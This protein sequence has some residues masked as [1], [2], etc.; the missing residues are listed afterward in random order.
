[1]SASGTT[2]PTLTVD[3]TSLATNASA[4]FASAFTVAYGADGAG[5]TT[6]ALAVANS[7]SG[8]IDVA[9]GE[10]IVLSTDASGNVVGKTATGG[11]TVFTISV[12]SSGVV[13]LDQVRAIKH[14]DA[15]NADDSVSL[16]ANSITLTATATDKDGDTASQAIN[17]GAGFVFKDDGPTVTAS[18]NT[19]VTVTLDETARNAAS[20]AGVFATPITVTSTV[21]V[22]NSTINYGADGAGSTVYSIKAVAG[23]SGLKTAVGD[24]AISLVQTSGSVITGTY[25]DSTGTTKTAF[26]ITM[27]TDGKLTVSQFVALEHNTDGS[28]SAAYDDVLQLITGKITAQVAVTDR[29]GDVATTSAV[30]I[31][32]QIIFKDD[33]PSASNVVAT[34]IL[35]EDGLSGGI[36]GGT[37]D[38]AGAATTATGSLVYSGGADGVA[39]IA[40]S[41]GSTTLGTET[42]TSTWDASTS[43]LTISS[44]R[45]DL[46]TIS[47]DQSTGTYTATLLKP[48]MHPVSGTEDNITLPLTYTVTDNDGD[49]AS[50]T[51]TLTVNDDMPVV[52]ATTQ[53]MAIQPGA[54]NLMIIL[55]VS[56]SMGNYASS[57]QTRLAMAKE[58]IMNLITAYDKQ[59][60]VRVEMVTFSTTGQ[61]SSVWMTTAQA[62]VYIN[63]L[64]AN[65]GT[66]YDDALQKAMDGFGSPGK[67][68]NAQNVAYFLTDGQPTYSQGGTDSL[69]GTTITG[70]GSSPTSS[71]DNGIQAAEEALWKQFLI[72]NKIISY[73]LGMGSDL[74][75]TDRS[76][77]DPIAYNGA[78]ST[79]LNG[80]IVSDMSQLNSTLQSLVI[81]PTVD[82]NLLRGNLGVDEAGSGADGSEVLMLTMAGRTYEYNSTTGALTASGTST[83]TYTYDSTTH[84]LTITTAAGAKMIL[85]MDTGDY[86][87]QAGNTGSSY[88]EQ[89]SY[90]VKD[91]DGDV[92]SVPTKVL[93]VYQISAMDDN[94]LTNDTDGTLSIP[95]AV[96]MANDVYTSTTVISSSAGV[97]GLDATGTD[98]VVVTNSSG[99]TAGFGT[100][101]A[102]IT[103]SSSDSAGN[104]LN[105]TTA[106]AVVVNRSQFGPTTNTNAPSGGYT[107]LFN[108]SIVEQAYGVRDIDMIQVTLKAGEKLTLDIDGNGSVDTYL[109]VLNAS[110]VEVAQNDDS[111]TIDAGSSVLQDSYLTYT[112]PSDGVY[113]IA[114]QSYSGRDDGTYNLWMNIQPATNTTGNGTFEYTLTEGTV[115]DTAAAD[116]TVSSGATING[117]VM[118]DTLIGKDGQNDTL[119][120]GAGDDVLYGGTGND[121][122][123]GG[124]GADKFVFASALS[125]TNTNSDV[126]RDFTSG[127]DKLVLDHHIFTG[128]SA[129]A[130]LTSGSTLIS[131]SSPVANTAS[132]TI[133]YNTSTGALSYDADGSGSGAAV[134]FGYLT[135]TSNTHPTISASDFIIL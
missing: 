127:T 26:T 73:S 130:T 124:T 59:G 48:L 86:S 52:D 115:T 126:I 88:Q 132:P 22:L 40:L 68:E 17:L 119:N 122:L 11:V 129:G 106:T 77:I 128:F 21:S 75:S 60:E 39:S 105:D 13:T 41:Y 95:A 46:M 120:G 109:R 29:D 98:P 64:Q 108:G 38:V 45:G 81:L 36:A 134:V 94:I 101:A 32:S 83:S 99:S 12:S 14:S 61:A 7:A 117:T 87:Y 1:M 35:D 110:G 62:M 54:T 28:T 9:T 102:T 74:T 24:Y 42:V 5:S 96:L 33:G 84:V 37:G 104:K 111:Q 55:D 58:A 2:A 135:T 57:T 123:T 91:M 121:I 97:S 90:S 114:V 23:D 3:E 118:N 76:Y 66:N 112:V 67:L 133:L 103:E 25:V 85:D 78:T 31:S 16:A 10:A 92:V 47:V 30:D 72:D 79:D 56:G 70:N 15:S 50:A 65:G 19:S 27:G 89:L 116:V 63:A 18:A 71:A 4:S 51:L 8:L 53:T 80:I 125:S 44:T 131:A 49:T 113:Y 100:S 6:Y 93:Q 107:A 69:K 34:T 20:T 82:T 43:T